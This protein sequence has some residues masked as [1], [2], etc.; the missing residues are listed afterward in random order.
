VVK[1]SHL[2]DGI[3]KLYYDREDDLVF[4]E[5][6]KQTTQLSKFTNVQIIPIPNTLEEQAQLP[7]SFQKILFFANSDLTITYSDNTRSEHVVFACEITKAESA[8]DHWLQRFPSMVGPCIC[9]VPSAVVLAFESG[10][11]KVK[12]DFF[13]AINRVVELHKSPLC[14]VEWATAHDEILS[15]DKEF[16][17]CPDRNSQSMI[18]LIIFI[19]LVIDYTVNEKDLNDLINEK[20]CQKF[21]DDMESRIAGNIPLPSEHKRLCALN[22]DGVVTTSE[23]L[24]WLNKKTGINFTKKPSMRKKNLIWT[25]YYQTEFYDQSKVTKKEGK[26]KSR[27]F[28]N[29]GDPYSGMPLAMDY[30]FC[31]TGHLKQDR[32]TNL[33]LNLSHELSYDEFMV[34][35]KIHHKKSPF[36]DAIPSSKEISRLSI[37]LTNPAIPEKKTVIRNWCYLADIIVLKDC[38]IPFHHD[39]HKSPQFK[40]TEG[41]ISSIT[42]RFFQK[43]GFSV[44]SQS[45]SGKDIHY[46]TENANPPKLKAPDILCYKDSTVIVGE[47]KIEYDKLFQGQPSDIEKINSFLNN[48]NAKAEFLKL[49]NE[50]GTEFKQESIIGGFSSLSSSNSKHKVDKNKIQTVID[51]DSTK[52]TINLVNDGGVGNIFPHKSL[53]MYI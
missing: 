26:L 39:F 7:P 53:D 20:I 41:T 51:I 19:D 18:D 24:V 11:G 28:K 32:D 21:H 17:K 46:Q 16:T 52:C 2:K 30:L 14:L 25:P 47:Q 50:F 38:I 49:M 23:M 42:R 15:E 8:R 48:K 45:K 43:N 31:R 37:H 4:S 6:I 22:S 1:N 10:F 36:L 35:F 27:I 3:W 40:I 13:Y 29:D 34:Y 33:I 44:I 9:G 12:S 5:L